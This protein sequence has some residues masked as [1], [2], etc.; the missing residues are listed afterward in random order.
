MAYDLVSDKNGRRVLLYLLD[1]TSNRH[2]ISS[3][4]STLSMSA[5]A[6]RDAGTS[7]KDSVVR[8]KELLGYASEGFLKLVEE[9]GEELVRD[10]GAGLVVQE[11]MLHAEGG[12]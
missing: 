7:K 9:N 3:T 12:P 2:F 4:L 11:I 6:A 5:Q 1:P 10:P 8:R